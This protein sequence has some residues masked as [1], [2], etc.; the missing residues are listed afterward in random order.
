MID[1]EQLAM[2]ALQRNPNIAKS[3]QGQ[4]FMQILQSKDTEKGI[5]MAKNIC[6]SYRTTPQDAY[7]KAMKFFNLN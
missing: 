7:Q 1:L 4:Q 3:P 5:Q 6:Q 2:E